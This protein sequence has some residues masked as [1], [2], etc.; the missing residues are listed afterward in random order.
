MPA[1]HRL[2]NYL[3]KHEISALLALAHSVWKQLA[4]LTHKYLERTPV[5]V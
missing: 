5:G 1:V 3:E 2:R 4:T